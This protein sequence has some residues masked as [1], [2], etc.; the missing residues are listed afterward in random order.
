MAPNPCIVCAEL[1]GKN[2]EEIKSQ[3]C[4]SKSEGA[5]AV[6]I[7]LDLIHGFELDQLS[8]LI[9]SDIISV[10]S[11]RSKEVSEDLKLAALH[12]AVELGSDFVEVDYELAEKFFSKPLG[13]AKSKIIV[14]SFNY[15]STPPVDELIALAAKL[16]ETKADIVKIITAANDISDTAKIFKFLDTTKTPTISFALA[17]R[18]EISR[19]LAPKFNSFLTYAYLDD[20]SG[21][22]QELP[23]V[24]DAV[25]VYQIKRL[26]RQSKVFGVVGNPISQSRGYLLYNAGMIAKNFDGIY[27]PFLVDDVRLF[28]KTFNMPDLIAGTSV[29][30]P[31]RQIAMDCIDEVD[32]AAKAIGAVSAIL[33][34]PDGTMIGYNMDWGAAIYAVEQGLLEHSGGKA[35]GKGPLEGVLLVLAGAGGAG[36]GLAYG[37]KEKGGYLLVADLDLDRAQEVATTFGGDV[38]SV[39]ELTAPDAFEKTLKKFCGHLKKAPVLCH[40]TPVGMKPHVDRTIFADVSALKGYSVVFD[41]V[42]NPAETRLQRE[43]KS[44]G[45][46]TVSGVEM[47]LREADEQ[48]ELFTGGIPAPSQVHR[49]VLLKNLSA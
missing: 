47:F 15:E 43:A 36:R 33:R 34:R 30:A 4:R 32:P 19:L 37:V 26:T 12:K 39:K 18:G 25:H 8:S 16:K 28:F 29:T 7:R 21:S 46:T 45:V 6:E 44:I 1:T 20:K 48:F 23:T 17:A 38:T 31:H 49:D 42:Y 27:L 13:G 35:E 3:I 41:A 9:P 14:A 40:A 22:A 24:Y 2:V 10:V 11:Y 5:D